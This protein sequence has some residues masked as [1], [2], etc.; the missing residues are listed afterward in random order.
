M[1]PSPQAGIAFPFLQHVHVMSNFQPFHCCK[2]SKSSWSLWP[3][4]QWL[5]PQMW[6]K[7]HF[8]NGP[9]VNYTIAS[10]YGLIQLSAAW[11]RLGK[12]QVNWA[13][14][15]N[16]F[17]FH[18]YLG[19]IPILTNIFQRGWNHQLVN[20]F[21]FVFSA[22]PGYSQRFCQGKVAISRWRQDSQAE[23]GTF[24]DRRRDW[25]DHRWS[26]QKRCNS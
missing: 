2:T 20:K 11:L 22:P 10:V 15:S 8:R 24:V 1:I 7:R 16:I 21:M 25:K 4:C 5:D 26:R 18:P 12:I 14:V 9:W 19:K 23:V 13:V 6:P 17:Y 3:T